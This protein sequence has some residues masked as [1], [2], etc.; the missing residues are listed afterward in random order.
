MHSRAVRV[1]AED[2]WEEGG[3]AAVGTARVAARGMEA[4]EGAVAEVEAREE[5]AVARGEVEMVTE[6]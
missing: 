5:V 1:G 3:K 4:M 6:G 2:G